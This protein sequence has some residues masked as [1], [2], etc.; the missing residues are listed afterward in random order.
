MR[1]DVTGTVVLAEWWWT[2]ILRGLLAIAFGV[3]AFAAPAWGI[4]I[5]VALFAA[6][7]LIDGATSLYLG[8]RHRA[9]A[10]SWWLEILEGL[11]GIA[12]GV[13]ALLFPGFAAEILRLLIAVWAIVTGVFE[14][15]MAVRLRRQISGEFWLGLAGVAS[16]MFG[17]VLVLFPGAGALSLVW[18]IGSFAL[19]F[20]IFLVI[21]GWRLR[22]I[23]EMAKID[24]AH[25]YSR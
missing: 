12:A 1:I 16:I 7:A 19:V 17:V 4:A 3:L 20:G 9:T 21:L 11:A 5:L 2:F 14:I 18:L 25:D 10:R 13:I 15:V 23:H 8:F 22:R 6:W 24:A